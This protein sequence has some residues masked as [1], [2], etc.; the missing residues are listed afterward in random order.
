MADRVNESRLHLFAFLCLDTL[1]VN[2]L[3]KFTCL[4]KAFIVIHTDRNHY[5][6]NTDSEDK[7]YQS[8][9]SCQYRFFQFEFINIIFKT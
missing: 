1:P 6:Q 2:F 9:L 4:F 3:L 8:V 7:F 5:D